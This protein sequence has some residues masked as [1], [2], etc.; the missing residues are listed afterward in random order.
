MTGAPGDEPTEVSTTDPSPDD[1]PHSNRTARFA[2][3]A[4]VVIL[5]GVVVLIVYALTD[6]PVTQLTVHRATASSTVMAELAKVPLS[7]FDAVGATAPDAQLV[8]PTVL[9]GQPPLKSAGKPEVLYVGAEY[10]PFCGAERW[11][12]IVA[13][14][15]FGRFSR[16]KNMQSAPLSVF[17]GIQTFSFVGAT[18]TSP[19]VSFTGVE[20]YSD[21]LDAQGAFARIAHL[22]PTQSALEARYGTPSGSS[23]SPPGPLPFVDIGNRLVTSTS[24]FSPA[25]IIKQPQA[26]IAGGL[27]QPS[28]PVTQA[29]VAAANQ[30]T[31]GICASTGQRPAAVCS[32][33]GVRDAADSLA[34]G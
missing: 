33:K 13:L 22:S 6:A 34:L 1:R 11:P 24:A 31:A 26:A 32:S 27:T 4:V 8:A 14:S 7:V 20:L 19:Y 9:T 16:L 3:G 12:L 21:A 18:Y 15:R 25:L 29:I 23:G 28:E 17:P 30:L 10:C 2:W 5:I